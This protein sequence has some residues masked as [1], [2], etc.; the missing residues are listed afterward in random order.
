MSRGPVNFKQRDV[1][2][3]I[4]AAVQAGQQV[5]RIEIHRDGSII[6]ILTGGKN[7]LTGKPDCCGNEWDA[8]LK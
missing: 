8:V 5:D 3:A 4:R 1:A 7:Q 6:V 2:A